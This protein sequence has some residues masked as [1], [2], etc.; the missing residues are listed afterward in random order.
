MS[1]KI[2]VIIGSIREGRRGD[3]VANWFLPIINAD[4]RFEVAVVDLK[5]YP[6]DIAMEFKEPSEYEDKNYSDQVVREFSKKIDQAEAFIFITP[7][8]NHAVPA[9]VKNA[10]D[11]IYYEWLNKPVGFVGYGSRGAV[12]SIDS[13][14]HTVKALKWQQI[15]PTVKIERVKKAFDESGNLIEPEL[16]ESEAKQMLDNLIEALN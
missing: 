5:D 2:A 15:E 7:E 16:P 10:I 6:M 9:S 3:I 8:Y 13:L 12:D 4:D 11:H 14:K 1:R